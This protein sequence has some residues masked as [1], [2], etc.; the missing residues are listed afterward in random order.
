[1][2]DVLL[3]FTGEGVLPVGD[4]S[5]TVAELRQSHLVTGQGNSS[6]SWDKP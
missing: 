6:Q 5:L 2:G 1:M 3:P 4:Y